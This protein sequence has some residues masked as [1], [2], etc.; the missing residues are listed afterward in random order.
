MGKDW[1]RDFDR[2][3]ERPLSDLSDA[4]LLREGRRLRGLGIASDSDAAIAVSKEVLRRGWVE[5]PRPPRVEVRDLGPSKL[6]T[7]GES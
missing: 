6:L 3:R 7:E 4:E 2:E 5:D 1:E